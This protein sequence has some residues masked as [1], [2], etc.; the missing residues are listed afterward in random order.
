MSSLNSVLYQTLYVCTRVFFFIGEL[1]RTGSTLF[2]IILS[3]Y[4]K[5]FLLFKLVLSVGA[6]IFF[7]SA[8]SK[9]YCIVLTCIKIDGKWFVET[10]RKIHMK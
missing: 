2:K 7:I 1:E 3:V 10:F 6:L 5:L 4:A 8:K 9:R